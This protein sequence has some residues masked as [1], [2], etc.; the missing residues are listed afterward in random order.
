MRP[1]VI[2][3]WVEKRPRE[4]WTKENIAFVRENYKFMT[5][6]ELAFNT[7]YSVSRVSNRM[8]WEGITALRKSTRFHRKQVLRI[9]ALQRSRAMNWA[10]ENRIRGR[11]IE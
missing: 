9:C 5:L 10:I 1:E 3:P 11:F 7:G 4:E 8:M 6:E 2:K